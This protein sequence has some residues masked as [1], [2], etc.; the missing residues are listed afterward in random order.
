MDSTSTTGQHAETV[1]R[2]KS[3]KKLDINKRRQELELEEKKRQATEKNDSQ[4]GKGIVQRKAQENLTASLMA[5]KTRPLARYADDVELNQE[6]KNRDRWG[7]PMAFLTKTKSKVNKR[8]M[9]SGPMPPPNRFGILPGYRWDG[10]D[11]SNGFE[12]KYYSVQNAKK[13]QMEIA[14]KWS[15]EV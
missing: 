3:G 7:D 8:P 6:L 14:Y 4:W 11:R 9:Y 13:S 2:D 12:A 15:T 10:I 1:Y 5:E